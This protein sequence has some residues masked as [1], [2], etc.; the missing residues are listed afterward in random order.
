MGEVILVKKYQCE[1]CGM[2]SA[3]SPASEATMIRRDC[4]VCKEA[5]AHYAVV[6]DQG[7]ADISASMERQL[8]E[9]A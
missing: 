4:S 5:T 2:L 6:V 3:C 7:Q 9:Q 8:K 1:V